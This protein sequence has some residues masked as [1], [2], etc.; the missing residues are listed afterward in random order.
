MDVD[1]PDW[2]RNTYGHLSNVVITSHN[3]I[4]DLVCRYRLFAQ[5]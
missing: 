2:A 5:F 3:E 1:C 4:I